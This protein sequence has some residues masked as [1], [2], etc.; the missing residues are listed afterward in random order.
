MADGLYRAVKRVLTPIADVYFSLRATGCETLPV[1]P[2]ILAANHSSLLDWVFVARFVERPIRFVLS[3]EFYDQATFTPLYRRLGVVPIRDGA[4]ELSAV[5]QL[6]ANLARGEIVGVFPEGRIT[7]D[8]A[9]LPAQPGIV[10]IAARA[11]V[12]IVPV[13]VRGAFEAFPRSA[14][15]P[16]RHPV[17]VAYGTPFDVPPAAARARDEQVRVAADLMQRIGE[18]CRAS[19]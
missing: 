17:H 1:G 11:G 9:L 7:L 12:P 19:F 13:G 10:S 8:G 15:L 18:L 5:R 2:F 14:R 4:I 16:R 3:R 6:L